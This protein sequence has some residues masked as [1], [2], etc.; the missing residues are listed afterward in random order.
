MT[1]FG[2]TPRPTQWAEIVFSP[3]MIMPQRV[4]SE[5]IF[6]TPSK[7]CSGSG[8]CILT[9]HRAAHPVVCV[10]PKALA[11]FSMDVEARLIILEFEWS[12]LSTEIQQKYF[13]QSYFLMDES[14]K[15]PQM[16]VKKW[17]ISEKVHLQ[18]GLHVVYRYRGKV[19]VIFSY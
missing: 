14:V 15:V 13:S 17:K 19:S 10:C 6:G 1:P 8:I 3:P 11:W 16:I 2:I 12:E 5:V 7:N 4:R 9:Q 18:S